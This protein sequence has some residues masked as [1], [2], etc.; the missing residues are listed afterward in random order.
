M[1]ALRRMLALDPKFRVL[2]VHGLTD[3]QAPYFATALELASHNHYDL[4]II[5]YQMPG[6]NGVDLFRQM[7][8]Q[9]P[10]IVGI[11]LTGFTTIDVV[12]PAIDAGV[13]R[14]LQK[15]VDFNELLPVI[16]EYVGGPE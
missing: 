7:H 6:M 2:V 13:M 12:F 11:F 16:E 10:E 14:V 15:P 8:E 5:D 9:H 4:A 1:L 3:V